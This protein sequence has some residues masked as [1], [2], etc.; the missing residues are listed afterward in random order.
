MET[1]L[2]KNK[3]GYGYCYTDL[4]EIHRYLEQNNMRY[5]QEVETV[6][7]VDYIMTYR[8]IDGKWEEKPKRGCRVVNAIL[9]GKS[10]PAQ[11]QGSALT[12]ARRYS[13]LMAFGLATDDDD[14]ESLSINKEPTINDAKEYVLTFGKNAGKKLGEIDKSYLNWLREYGKDPYIKKCVDLLDPLP[15]ED[16]Q[17]EILELMTEL[18]ALIDATDTDREQLYKHYGVKSDAELSLEQLKDAVSILEK[19]AQ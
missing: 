3:E 6:D 12:Y 11:E 18:H 17:N 7:G 8:F 10:N 5:Y 9:S 2:N 15:S 14:A 19:K 1:T 16:E 4:A 13:L